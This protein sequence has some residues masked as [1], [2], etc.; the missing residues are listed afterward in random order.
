MQ[1]HHGPLRGVRAIDLTTMFSGA[2]GASLLAD[3]GADVIKVELPGRGDPV[4]AMSP[5][6]DG[7]SLTWAVL[8]RNKRNITLDLRAEQG[9]ELLLRLVAGSDVLFENFRPGTLD[10]WGLDLAT[11]RGAQPGIIVVRVS[12]YGQTG[13]YAERAG[14]GTPATAFSGLTYMTGFP[15]RPPVSQPFPLADYA[16]GVFAGLAAV[17]ALYHRDARGGDGQEVDIAL[18]ESLFRLIESTVPAYDQLGIVAE[19]RGNAMGVAS[20]VGT[21]AAGDGRWIVLTASTDRTWTRLCQAIEAPELLD[22]PRFLTNELRVTNNDALEPLV[23]AWFGAR[24]R[25][26]AIATLDAA[27]VPASPIHSVADICDDAHYAARGNIIEVEHPVLG[28]LRMP[29]VVPHFSRT[30]GAVRH[31]GHHALGAFNDEVFGELLGLSEA[32][33]ARLAADGVI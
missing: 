6:R 7:V 27:G 17:M 19:R 32:E 29:G 10:R 4:R 28:R 15:D 20:P 25:D 31:P 33:R 12:G 14:F 24:T 8:S 1:A 3:F 2:F 21:F 26:E 22:D 11:L 5:A 16:T 18:Y 9:R 30:P 23:A 13:P